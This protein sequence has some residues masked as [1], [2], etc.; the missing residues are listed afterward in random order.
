M[1]LTEGL[2]LQAQTVNMR[3]RHISPL[4]DFSSPPYI[5]AEPGAHPQERA[6]PVLSHGTAFLQTVLILGFFSR[7]IGRSLPT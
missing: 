6:N 7:K 1:K 5:G 4:P 3:H 2:T